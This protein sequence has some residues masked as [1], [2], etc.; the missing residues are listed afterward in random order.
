MTLYQATLHGPTLLSTGAAVANATLVYNSDAPT[1]S[2]IA[3]AANVTIVKQIIACNTDA[4]ARTFSL[5]L[6]TSGTPAVANTILEG[7]T[8]A[9]GETKIINTSLVLRAD[10]DQKLYARASVNSLVTLTL[11]G[12]EE[13]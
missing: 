1:T 10:K 11:V 2:S 7:V 12:I 4:S 5:Y 6:N 3:Q 9:A 8:L 13:Y